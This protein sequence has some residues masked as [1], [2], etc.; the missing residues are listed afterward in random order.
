LPTVSVIIP[1]YNRAALVGDVV[2]S[3]IDQVYPDLE[4]IVVDDGSTDDTAHVVA[5]FADPRVRYLYR[6]HGG[7]SAAR[8][9]G[10]AAS[11]GKYVSFVD[12]DDVMLPHNLQILSR[13]LEARP[14]VGIAYGWAYF[15]RVKDG[16][17]ELIDHD[18]LPGDL[19]V[20]IDAPWSGADCRPGGVQVEGHI[21]PD[22]LLGDFMF[23]GGN[24]IR[25]ECIDAIGGFDTRI[26]YM[27]HW[28]FYLRLAQARFTYACCRQ[29][30]M[31]Y[32]RHPGSRSRDS[33]AMLRDHLAIID[34]VFGDP[35]SH[36]RLAG[37]KDRAY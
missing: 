33:D 8:N 37:L 34:R 2:R 15:C 14:D 11:R 22:L 4:L 25:R 13:T 20:Q 1:T 3:V 31:L 12:S 27:E 24:L 32:Q 19:P 29:A 5:A 23:L 30:V 18:P 26:Q 9:A 35:V 36:P 7:A 10:L 21:L 16:R 6:D 17:R 28:D